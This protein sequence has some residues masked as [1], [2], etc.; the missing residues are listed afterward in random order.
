MNL[1]VLFLRILACTGGKEGNGNAKCGYLETYD[2][3]PSFDATSG[4]R[5]IVY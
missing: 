5:I 3:A 2:G 4:T 1:I